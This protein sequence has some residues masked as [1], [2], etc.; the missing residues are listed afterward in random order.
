[1]RITTRHKAVYIRKTGKTYYLMVYF[2]GTYRDGS[3]H[4]YWKTVLK[5]PVS[6]VEESKE[7]IR[8]I[9]IVRTMDIRKKSI[10]YLRFTRC[11]DT[12]TQYAY[13]L[14]GKKIDTLDLP[15]IVEK[16]YNRREERHAIGKSSQL[17]EEVIFTC[18]DDRI[19]DISFPTILVDT[20][21]TKTDKFKMK[22]ENNPLLIQKRSSKI[23]RRFS[24]I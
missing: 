19:L 13:Y 17:D 5:I 20:R 1:M 9:K 11:I 6:S 3:H 16:I 12:G 23:L 18:L 21:N 8:R 7:R 15:A 4:E 2:N 24:L 10:D 14:N 22:K